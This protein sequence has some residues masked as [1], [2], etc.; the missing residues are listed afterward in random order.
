[1]KTIL[2]I[3]LLAS[4]RKDTIGRC[5]ESLRPIRERIPSE[6]VVIDTGCDS[7]V[8][9]LL[10]SHADVV[11]NFAWCNDFSAAR[12][13]TLRYAHGEWYLY[14]DDD[15]W[16]TDA[17]ELICFFES[18][19]YLEYGS[20]SYIQRNYLDAEGT[21]YTDTWVARMI[22]REPDTHFESRI[23]E[24]LTPVQGKSKPLY[25][26]V[27]HYGYVY[28]DE[29]AKRAHFER[30][31][32]LLEEMI[33][34]EPENIR[35]RLQLL[36]EY[37]SVDDFSHMYELGETGLVM[38]RAQRNTMD[39]LAVRV[40]LGTFYGAQ[41]MASIG[42]E[43]YEKAKE[44]AFKAKQDADNTELFQAALD[45]WLARCCYF[46]KDYREA[47]K[48]CLDYLE[49][50]AQYQKNPQA[51]Y[52][53]KIAPFVG[54][55]F[56]VGHVKEMYSILICSGLR[57]QDNGYLQE[58]L[59]ELKWEE[60]NIYVFEDMVPTVIDAMSRMPE[61]EGFEKTLRTMYKHVPLW[62]YFCEELEKYEKQGNDVSPVMEHIRNAV[63]EAVH[64]E[65][66]DELQKLAED[67]RHQIQILMENGMME[68]ARN[69]LGQVRQ[70]LPQD[71]ELKLLE[72]KLSEE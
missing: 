57:Q 61:A 21:E 29:A 45:L 32:T 53:Q 72:Q 8:R 22:R 51:Y 42:Q 14:L 6:L 39:A 55:C 43:Q 64:T 31:R 25:S 35:W 24:Y 2:T 4:N 41:I 19:E 34:D 12:N 56:D 38:I 67:I 49:R 58:Y 3:A 68:Q 17:K 71:E 33:E 46:L 30:N 7:E 47:E 65:E 50:L 9:K 26:V 62:E 69:I 37:R 1:M 52:Q 13:E 66:T 11:E 59:P 18:G 5:L 54:E 70:L 60:K 16:F 15:E 48:S 23:H 20:A 10:E 63:P 40:Y 36:Q 44:L 28:P 27:E